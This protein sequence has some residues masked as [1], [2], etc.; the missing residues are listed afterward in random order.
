MNISRLH[1]YEQYLERRYGSFSYVF[2]RLNKR[3]DNVIVEL[4]TTRSFVRGGMPGC[5]SSDEIFW[6]E[7][8]I[9]NWDWSAGGFS[10]VCAELIHNT[11]NE[12]YT[13]D[14]NH[15]AMSICK[16]ITSRF[17]ENVEY[18]LTTSTDFLTKV[19]GKIDLLYMDHHET[20]EEGAVLHLNDTKILLKRNLL[21]EDG[22]ILID[23][24][25]LEQVEADQ[26][27]ARTTADFSDCGKGKYSIPFLLANGFQI[28]FEGYQVVL[29]HQ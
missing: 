11:Q 22:M 13:V 5:M 9:S 4:G 28:V 29:S 23:D 2:N 7:N 12:L 10:R 14:L 19:E 20:C 6:D 26:I 18:V 15:D 17:N 8:N 24:V 1:F 25:H 27:T 3:N 16:V 21:A